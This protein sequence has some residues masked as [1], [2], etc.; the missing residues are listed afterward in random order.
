ML[1]SGDAFVWEIVSTSPTGSSSVTM[2]SPPGG[3]PRASTVGSELMLVP[4]HLIRA[5][6][7][8]RIDQCC[9][10]GAVMATPSA[11][12]APILVS[13]VW[14]MQLG[15]PCLVP[16][17]EPTVFP[18]ASRSRASTMDSLPRSRATTADALGVL[19][20]LPGWS[21]PQSRATAF[22]AD[23]SDPTNELGEWAAWLGTFKDCVVA[24]DFSSVRVHRV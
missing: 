18:E 14:F 23:V 4:G 19:A 20:P 22:L 16:W 3:R 15:R 9:I 1:Q 10:V 21:V 11:S 7:N 13:T 8:G 5:P 12:L 2:A 24:N 17:I 6:E